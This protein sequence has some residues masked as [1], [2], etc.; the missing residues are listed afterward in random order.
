MYF[1]HPIK[2]RLVPCVCGARNCRKV[3]RYLVE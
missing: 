1:N 3:L 2:T